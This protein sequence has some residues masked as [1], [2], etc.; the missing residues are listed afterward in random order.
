MQTKIKPVHQWT[1]ILGIYLVALVLALFSIRSRASTQEESKSDVIK[2]EATAKDQGESKSPK[3]NK[4]ENKKAE[5]MPQV[6]KGKNVIAV[7]DTS[8]GEFKLK[9]FADKAPKT[10][11]N[12]VGL[13][14][15]QLE[16]KDKFSG[17]TVKI[18][19][20]FYDGLIFHRIID[21]FMIQGG[22]PKGDGTGDPGYRFEDEFDKDLRHSKAG[23]ISMANAGPNTNGSQFFITLV[24]TPFLDGKHAVFGETVSDA[25]LEV[26][27]KIGK[28]ATGRQDRPLVPVVIKTI[29][30]I[31]E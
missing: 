29:K 31:E 21:G 18:T 9:L 25:D 13:A 6:T 28:V 10:V 2:T 5:K 30:I 11:A 12:F 23:V 19:K 17:K 20:P 26:V 1:K 3:E 16:Q 7:F 27:K 22:C 8:L 4:K 14:K 15:G 24:P